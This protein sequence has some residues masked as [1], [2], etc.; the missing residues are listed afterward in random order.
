VRRFREVIGN[1]VYVW[2]VESMRPDANPDELKD[3]LAEDEM[4]RALQ[5]KFAHDS[6][7][8]IVARAALRHILSTIL[9]TEPASLQFSTG[10]YGKPQLMKGNLQFNVSHSGVIALIAVAREREL[11][12]DIEEM[13]HL[14]DAVLI[15]KR[16]FAPEEAQ[17][18]AAMTDSAMIMRAF[19]ECWTRKEAFIKATGEGLS[20][21]LDAFHV[22]FFPDQIV[23]L[24]IRSE[25]SVQW[26]L[27]DVNPGPGYRAALV[28]KQL[29]NGAIPQ[30]IQHEWKP[31]CYRPDCFVK[32]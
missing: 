27:V 6:R 20:R 31:P 9:D 18:I 24:R 25:A 30:I 2:R 23:E 29:A 16:F 1:D 32:T 28:F 19:F 14:D 22:T 26:S 21:P 13:R 7:R 17:Q 12:I 3:L 8:Y 10:P 11:G 4:N 15:A 5:F